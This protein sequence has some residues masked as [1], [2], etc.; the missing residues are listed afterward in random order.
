VS[1]TASNDDGSDTEVKEG[2][3]TVTAPQ[4]TFF[5]YAEGSGLYPPGY[6]ILPEANKTP[7]EIYNYLDGKSGAASVDPNIHWEG[8]GLYLDSNSSESHWNYYEQAGSYADNAD[9]SVFVGHGWNDRIIFG[10]Q[11]TDTDLYRENM[12][13]GGN[14]AK[15]VTFFACDVLNQT[16]HDNWTSA[17]NG[18]H[19]LNGF[20][21]DGLLYEG[22][23]TK[24]AQKL[25]GIGGGE[26]RKPIRTAWK[27]TLKETINKEYIRGASKW[28]E[29]C[30]DDFLPGFGNYNTPV[31]NGEGNYTFGYESFNCKNT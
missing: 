8:R 19:I 15:W 11:D 14:R 26:N 13:F 4:T 18:L 30:G 29:P 27:E 12:K 1:L 24:Y 16:Y 9:F 10:T 28:V 5:V 21:T 20:D 22:Q 31:K 25:T 23:G 2:Y 3:V 7:K 6:D 17:F